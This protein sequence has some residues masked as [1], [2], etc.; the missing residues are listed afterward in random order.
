MLRLVRFFLVDTPDFVITALFSPKFNNCHHDVDE[1]LT[2]FL[3]KELTF[4]EFQ[5][6]DGEHGFEERSVCVSDPDV[7]TQDRLRCWMHALVVDVV[8]AFGKAVLDP[9]Q[10]IMDTDV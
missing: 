5:D 1:C 7:C 9:R 4:Q 3:A 6:C 2:K 8:F 10:F